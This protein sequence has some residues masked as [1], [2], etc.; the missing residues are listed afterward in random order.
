GMLQEAELKSPMF[1]PIKAN[2]AAVDSDKNGTLSFQET[3][4]AM[5]A[6]I[7]TLKNSFRTGRTT[8]S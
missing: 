7:E 4:A 6:M 8:R 2:F 5:K 3:G 1:Q